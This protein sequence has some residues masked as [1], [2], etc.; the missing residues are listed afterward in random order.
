M[1]ANEQADAGFADMS[2]KLT[3]LQ[4]GVAMAVAF[5]CAVGTWAITKRMTKAYRAE[6]VTMMSEGGDGSALAG[7]GGQLGG[8]AALLGSSIGPSD[9]TNESLATLRSRRLIAE[10]LRAQ[11]RIKRL[12]T[13]QW[14]DDHQQRTE[15]EH[16]TRAVSFMQANVL[17]VSD[18]RRTGT[19]RVS[20]TWYDRN[21]A[22][23]W[24]NDYVSAANDLLRS[25]AILDARQSIKYLKQAAANAESVELQQAVYRLLESQ[26]K[27]EMLA[28][29]RPEFALR[30]IDPATVPPLGGH[31]RPR[32]ALLGAAGGAIGALLAA[33][34]I[35]FMRWWRRC[36]QKEA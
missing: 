8:V 19:I 13:L 22:A 14:P 3:R 24:A 27:S 29:T 16:M 11:N 9:K 33:G 7:L 4:F 10:F 1:H 32:P 5:V 2:L 35:L 28:T 6:T 23:A 25:R 31:V 26:V 17:N 15:D 34:A 20:M 30:I 36:S 18:D 21:E 12:E